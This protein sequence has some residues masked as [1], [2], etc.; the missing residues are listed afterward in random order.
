MTCETPFRGPLIIKRDN[1]DMLP[2]SP[3][4][5]VTINRRNEEAL[6]AHWG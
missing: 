1:I 3:D 4:A 2:G 5:A 6:D